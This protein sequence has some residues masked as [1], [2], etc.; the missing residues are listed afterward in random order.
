M[1]V[2]SLSVAPYTEYSFTVTG[3]TPAGSGPTS[4]R[5][6]FFTPQGRKSYHTR[7]SSYEPSSLSLLYSQLLLL[8]SQY[9]S[10]I[11]V[12]PH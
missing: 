10:Q 2:F 4:T 11:L 7:I 3:F 1:I 6:T 12:Q 9:V 5:I 8:L